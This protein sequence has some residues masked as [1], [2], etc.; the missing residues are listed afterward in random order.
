MH[1]DSYLWRKGHDVCGHFSSNERETLSSLE[2]N[3]TTPPLN[4]LATDR[5]DRRLSGHDNIDP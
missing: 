5:Q 1:I 3:F 2:V 4:I